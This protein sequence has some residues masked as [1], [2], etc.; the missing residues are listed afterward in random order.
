MGGSKNGIKNTKN[1]IKKIPKN[2]IN[3]PQKVI[4]I[5]N[6]GMKSN[7]PKKNFLNNFFSFDF[8]YHIEKKLL[9][10]IC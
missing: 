5:L 6:S 10:S 3:F 4:K 7:F 8:A 9:L 1:G 2:V